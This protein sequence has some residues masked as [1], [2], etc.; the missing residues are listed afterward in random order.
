M[1]SETEVHPQSFLFDF[2]GAFFMKYTFGKR[3][4]PMSVF[5]TIR[6]ILME[7]LKMFLRSRLYS[8]RPASLVILL[9]GNTE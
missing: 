6:A 9:N 5:S 1:V 7:G 8:D 2:W 4:H 3:A